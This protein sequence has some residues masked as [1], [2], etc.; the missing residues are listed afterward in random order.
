M[1][2]FCLLVFLFCASASFA[3]NENLVRNNRNQIELTEVIV[4]DSFPAAQLFLNAQLF[5]KNVFQEERS[6]A[7]IRDE[8]AKVVGA[9]AS[10]SVTIE[11][12]GGEELSAKA[13]FTI[14]IQSKENGYKYTIGDFYFGYTEETGITSYASFT[15]HLGVYMT[16]KQWQQVETQTAGFMNG[17]VQDLK[18]Q[19]L[20]KEILCKEMLSKQRKRLMSK[21]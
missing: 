9:R 12:V 7:Q 17:F 14:F 5:L 3:Q 21:P 1:K 19:M 20:Q 4:V 10:I 16:K 6:S 11:S 15:D 8:K 2:L 18:Q 13:Y